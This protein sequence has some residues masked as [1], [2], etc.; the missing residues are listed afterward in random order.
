MNCV[1]CKIIAGEIP[2]KRVY[3]DDRVIAFLDQNPVNPGHTLLVPKNHSENSIEA[4]TIDLCALVSALQKISPVIRDVVG[5]NGINF[6]I[7]NGVAAGQAIMHTHWHII[8]RFYTDGLKL[9]NSVDLL[10]ED[11]TRIADKIIMGLRGRI[12]T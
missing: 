4:S 6:L 8:P 7:N 10:P 12:D 11:A 1:F 5:A 9:W 3:E 2:H